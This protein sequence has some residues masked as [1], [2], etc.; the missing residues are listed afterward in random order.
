LN[1]N[2]QGVFEPR[3]HQGKQNIFLTGAFT[4]EM[5]ISTRCFLIGANF[6][7]CGNISLLYSIEIAV[8]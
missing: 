3:Q 7:F 8:I 5:Y 2:Q 1:K 6:P 4:G